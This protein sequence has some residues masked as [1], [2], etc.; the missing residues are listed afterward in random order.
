MN[1]LKNNKL[2]KMILKTSCLLLRVSIINIIVSNYN[3][4][5]LEWLFL[6][7]TISRAPSTLKVPAFNH[8]SERKWNI[9]MLWTQKFE[10]FKMI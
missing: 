1:K 8:E 6:A 2:S 7:L 5:L 10:T 9:L 3:W 4:E